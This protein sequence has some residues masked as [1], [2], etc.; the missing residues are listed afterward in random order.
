MRIVVT[1]AAGH[2]GSHVAPLLAQRG[3][4]VVRTD[5]LDA[6]DGPGEFRKADL[7]DPAQA[8]AA[9]DGAE[10]VVHCASIHP[11]KKYTDD[12][13]LDCNIKATWH[14]FAAAAE[15]GI[16]RVVQTSSIA[17]YGVYGLPPDA[18]PV[19]EDLPAPDVLDL[20]VVTKMS[21]ELTAR[22]FASRCGLRIASLRPPAFMPRADL[23]TGLGLLTSFAVVDDIASA[24]VAAAEHID[25]LPN[26][27]EPFNITNALP[28][29]REDAALLATDPRA[30][31]ERYWPGAWD[32][33][34]AQGRTPAPHPTVF[35]L[36]KAKRLLDWE[37]THSFGWWWEKHRG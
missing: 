11:W 3:H 1:G 25:E 12:Q 6:P 30:V 37:P 10:L 8:R 5:I 2:L 15:L 33:F 4:E 31:M 9:L 28:Y 23:D 26:A 17:V 13:Y 27:F 32:W 14:V 34:V 16:T 18:W 29:S 20:Y 36:S 7:A 19:P 22:R 35:D 21:Q 24:H